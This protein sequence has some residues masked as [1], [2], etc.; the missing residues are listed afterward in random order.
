MGRSDLV[1]GA[2][3]TGVLAMNLDVQRNLPYYI[4]PVPKGAF[5]KHRSM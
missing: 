2:F 1:L 5:S 4:E 3:L